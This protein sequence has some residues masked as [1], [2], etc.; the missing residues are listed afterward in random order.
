[1]SQNLQ[2]LDWI[3]PGANI[4][5]YIQGANAIAILSAE[6]ERALA[7]DLYY[8]EDLDAARRLVLSHLRFRSQSHAFPFH[9][10]FYY[11]SCFG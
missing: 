3:T 7:E 6:E 10:C 5:A 11:Y 1:M 2:P 9:F 4:A 8:H